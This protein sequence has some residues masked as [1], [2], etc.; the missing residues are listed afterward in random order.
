MILDRETTRP[1]TFYLTVSPG[2]MDTLNCLVL[3][4]RTTHEAIALLVLEHG[5]KQIAEDKPIKRKKK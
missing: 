4:Y 2:A 1:N 5:L 3:K